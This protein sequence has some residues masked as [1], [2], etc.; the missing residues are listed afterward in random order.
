MGRLK[1]FTVCFILA[2]ALNSVEIIHST[3]DEIVEDLFT[4]STEDKEVEY[5]YP[6][7]QE[8]SYDTSGAS[9]KLL[10]NYTLG[11]RVSGKQFLR[12]YQCLKVNIQESL[13][14]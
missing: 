13:I 2:I 7:N 8:Q 5:L 3:I 6:L 1:A 10:F 9:P 11:A 12:F 14:R 4:I